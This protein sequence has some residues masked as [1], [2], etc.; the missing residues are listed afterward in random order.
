MYAG[1]YIMV[2]DIKMKFYNIS[3]CISK[4]ALL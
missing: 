1:T 4:N 2:D 3:P